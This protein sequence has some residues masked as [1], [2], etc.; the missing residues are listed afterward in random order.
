MTSGISRSTLTYTRHD[1]IFVAVQK[2]KF[3]DNV[4]GVYI[5]AVLEKKIVTVDRELKR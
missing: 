5:S 2:T 1:C 3:Y 4:Y